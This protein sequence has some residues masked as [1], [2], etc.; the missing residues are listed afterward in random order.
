M[1]AAGIVVCAWFCTDEGD[2]AGAGFGGGEITEEAAA[3]G[4]DD[5]V[6]STMV[7]R[8]CARPEESIR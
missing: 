1:A 4:S 6:P 7:S 3:V 2:G 8:P 5:E